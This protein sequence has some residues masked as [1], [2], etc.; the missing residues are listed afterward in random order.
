MDSGWN[1]FS[2][3]LESDAFESA[4]SHCSETMQS[5]FSFP[6]ATGMGVSHTSEEKRRF[7][8]RDVETPPKQSTQSKRS[9]PSFN[10]FL[11]PLSYVDI[12][13]ARIAQLQKILAQVGTVS[14]AEL[15]C[16]SQADMDNG[17]RLAISERIHREESKKKR[18][19]Q[20]RLQAETWASN[21]LSISAEL[22]D[23][24]SEIV[25]RVANMLDLKLLDINGK[26]W[27]DQTMLFGAAS[28]GHFN[29][30]ETLL[31]RGA[32]PNV[33][34]G[35]SVLTCRDSTSTPVVEAALHVA[36]AGGHAA[37]CD[38]L[39]EHKAAVDCCSAART[40][41]LR[42]A[43]N[44]NFAREREQIHDVSSEFEASSRPSARDSPRSNEVTYLGHTPLFLALTHGQVSVHAHNVFLCLNLWFCMRMYECM[45]MHV[46]MHM[47]VHMYVFRSCAQ[48]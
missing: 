3:Q 33:L 36:A 47:C 31:H 10:Q 46:C 34:C 20:L 14:I 19:V 30:A 11:G 38:L 25:R 41:S 5:K 9:L 27:L 42:T 21:R 12:E 29:L 37:V 45:C 26:D 6:A 39:L 8:I 44:V 35:T 7:I 15:P 48:G 13:N 16:L 22:H 32:D 23:G 17:K 1:P 43:R 24:G 4:E 40:D 18:T 28:R 2:S